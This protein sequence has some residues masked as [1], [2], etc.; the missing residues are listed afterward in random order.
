MLGSASARHH[1]DVQVVN[2]QHGAE[3][4]EA[5]DK[6][7]ER[8][9]QHVVC[10]VGTAGYM[11]KKDKVYAHLSDRRAARSNGTAGEYIRSVWAAQNDASVRMKARAK[12]TT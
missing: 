12:P 10:I 1:V 2:N 9:R 8:Q 4:H 5:D 6:H 11:Q 7:A 3:D